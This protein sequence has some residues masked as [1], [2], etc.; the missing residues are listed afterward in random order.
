MISLIYTFRDNVDGFACDISVA[1]STNCFSGVEYACDTTDKPVARP[2]CPE[3]GGGP[4]DY[5]KPGD[6]NFSGDVT[7]AD[8]GLLARILA[9]DSTVTVSA[10][11]SRFLDVNASGKTDAD[12]LTTLLRQLAGI[13]D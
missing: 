4:V 5:L 2:W 3:S 13:K 6:I 12:D 11:S 1:G 9:E 7:V 10:L 8:V